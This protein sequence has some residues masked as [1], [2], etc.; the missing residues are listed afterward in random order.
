MLQR[1]LPLTV[2]QYRRDRL[3]VQQ[4]RQA[5]GNPAVTSHNAETLAA[6]LNLSPRSLH[7][8]LQDEGASLQQ[9]KDE[10][11]SEKAKNLLLRT[12]KPIKQVAAASGFRNEKSFIRAFRVWTVSSPS[13]FRASA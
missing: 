12:T 5:L 8:Q 3:L 13:G 11:R 2:L 7:R 4:V 1:A 9:L 10:V 6:A